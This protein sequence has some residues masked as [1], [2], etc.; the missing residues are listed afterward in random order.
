MLNI[1]L[2]VLS[3]LLDQQI[4]DMETTILQKLEYKISTATTFKFYMRYLTAGHADKKL[5]MLTSFIL[6]ESLFSLELAT[7]WK[8]SQLAAASLMIGR[9]A[10]GRH[11]WS[12]TL[13]AYSEYREEDII[14]VARHMIEAKKNFDWSNLRSVHK[15]YSGSRK[16]DAA[17]IKISNI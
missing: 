10:V 12:P 1:T 11:K 15:K 17:H 2:L 8:P 9:H 7:K 5:I 3:A 16:F 6:E 14:P 13:L 4:L